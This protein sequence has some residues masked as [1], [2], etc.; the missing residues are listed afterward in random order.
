MTVRLSDV[1]WRERYTMEQD[2]PRSK[3]RS[4]TMG[5]EVLKDDYRRELGNQVY[6]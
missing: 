5:N 2:F 1:G 4:S 6:R 3:D